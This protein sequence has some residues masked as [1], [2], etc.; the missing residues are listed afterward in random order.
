MGIIT[1]FRGR[2]QSINAIPKLDP[3]LRDEKLAETVC[4]LSVLFLLPY[5]SKGHHS[6]LIL[7]LGGWCLAMYSCLVLPILISANYKYPVRWMRQLMSK[8]PD[9]FEKYSGPVFDFVRHIYGPLDRC[10]RAFMKLSNLSNMAIQLVFFMLCD[11]VLLYTGDGGE[12]RISG[13][14]SLMFYNVIAYCVSY[15]RELIT[16]EDWSPYVKITS[17]GNLKHLAMSA[18]KIVLEWTKAIT[19]IVTVTFMLLIFG[20]EQGLEFFQP[21]ALYTAI[22]WSYFV[23][24]ERV[25]VDMAP[26]ILGW[27][28]SAR[29]EALEH[30]YAP[31]ILR[32]Y[33]IAISAIMVT[34]LFLGGYAQPKFALLAFYLTVFL[35]AKDTLLTYLGDLRRQ[36]ALL[37]RFRRA[38]GAEIADRADDVCAVCLSKMRRARVTPCNHMFHADCLRRCLVTAGNCCP[39]CKREYT[40]VQSNNSSSGRSTSSGVGQLSIWVTG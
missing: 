23:C 7:S 10:E 28:R 9:L 15:I 12:R 5:C 13:L 11:R 16:K 4:L 19:F 26:M 2:L 20:L 6:P 33:T 17:H 25:F 8:M 35:R 31:V 22:T 32:Y 40:F 24:T 1:R 29:W 14:Y 34:V 21:T 39:I 38:S 27:I 3:K 30:L 18:T 37:G 36:Q